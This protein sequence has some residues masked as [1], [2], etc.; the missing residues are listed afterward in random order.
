[1]KKDWLVTFR[2]ITF[3]Q[4]AQRQMK[5]EGIYSALQKTPKGLSERGCSYSLRI[6]EAETAEA[7]FWLKQ[8]QIPYGKIFVFSESGAWEAQEG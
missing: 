1:M 2:S 6:S 3:A 8:Q 4:K 7:L 5:K